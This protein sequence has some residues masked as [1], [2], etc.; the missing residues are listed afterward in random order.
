M[1]YK[2]FDNETEAR[3][4]RDKQREAKLAA[5]LFTYGKDRFRVKVME[6]TDDRNPGWT[7]RCLSNQ[8]WQVSQD[9]KD[10]TE[11]KR[12]ID[13]QEF[14]DCDYES[15]VFVTKYL[16]KEG[17]FERPKDVI[18]FFNFPD[19]SLDKIREMVDTALKEYEDDWNDKDGVV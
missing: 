6:T 8:A 10:L 14:I 19:R 3:I 13:S 15:I 7:Q 5:S 18:E 11:V 1:I 4:F 12:I 2:D 16:N 17:W 9:I